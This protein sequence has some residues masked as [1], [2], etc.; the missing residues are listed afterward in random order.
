VPLSL[1]RL[2][3]QRRQEALKEA[4]KQTS[5]PG[6]G[7]R[8]GEAFQHGRDQAQSRAAVAPVSLPANAG[9]SMGAMNL[10]GVDAASMPMARV[11]LRLLAEAQQEAAVAKQ[12]LYD[13]R[14]QVAMQGPRESKEAAHEADGG[15]GQEHCPPSG[16]P[17]EGSPD[18]G[19]SPSGDMGQA[20]GA[21]S[22]ADSGAS[23][24]SPSAGADAK[25]GSDAQAQAGGEAQTN[26]PAPG[27]CVESVHAPTGPPM[28]TAYPAYAMGMGMGMGVG[29][30]GGQGGG[31][32]MFSHGPSSGNADL[33]IQ[34]MA[35]QAMLRRQYDFLRNQIGMMRQTA[36]FYGQRS[37]LK[38][39]Q[40]MAEFEK[41]VA[42]RRP[43]PMTMEEA[44]KRVDA[45]LGPDL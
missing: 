9:S 30:T 11:Y 42:A 6:V 25:P 21:P 14:R 36:N 19:V 29:L 18:G 38:S 33:D 24:G 45:G 23:P 31:L 13:L 1:L 39:Y 2:G 43:K 40:G 20:P 44:L 10:A 41:E 8:K 32:G 34:F 15:N 28:G 37:G 3:A 22:P 5:G 27:G 26:A 16:V 4:R 12:R 7:Y 17:M 35:R